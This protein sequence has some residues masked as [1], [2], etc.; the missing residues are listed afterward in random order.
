[1]LGASFSTAMAAC[2]EEKKF[3]AMQ[4]F[5]LHDMKFKPSDV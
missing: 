3:P 1:M 4:V 2:G 5:R